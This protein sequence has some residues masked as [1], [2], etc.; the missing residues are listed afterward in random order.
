[1]CL[2]LSAGTVHAESV[3]LV[4]WLLLPADP[5]RL[6]LGPFAQALT[7]E[8]ASLKPSGMQQSRQENQVSVNTSTGFVPHCKLT[9]KCAAAF[10]RGLLHLVYLLLDGAKE[11]QPPSG[12]RASAIR[13][14]QVTSAEGTVL[15]MCSVVYSLPPV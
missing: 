13:T 1:M 10:R 9:T 2:Q 12:T 4:R 7:L 11:R 5:S 6:Q 14:I 3:G 8:W 15:N